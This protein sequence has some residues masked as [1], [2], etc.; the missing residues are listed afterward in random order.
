M[1]NWVLEL[2]VV[3]QMGS[4]SLSF[5]STSGT[6]SGGWS[7]GNPCKLRGIITTL[8]LPGGGF[9]V[10]SSAFAILMHQ[11]QL[12][13]PREPARDTG[14]PEVSPMVPESFFEATDSL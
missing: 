8:G 10:C 11:A 6:A 1:A 4:L 9:N 13:D 7:T 5:G 14:K 12:R 2:S 3:P